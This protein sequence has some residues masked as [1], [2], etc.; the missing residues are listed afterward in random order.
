MEKS[1][2]EMSLEELWQLFPVILKAHNPCYKAWY[3]SEKQNIMQCINVEHIIRF[4]HIGSS[5]VENLISKPIIDILL[6]IDGCCD[7]VQ[8]V[9]DLATDGWTL[10]MQ[11]K[12]PTI[13]FAFNKGYMPNGF[14]QKVFHL[15]VRYFGDWSELYFRDYLFSHP[16]IAAEYGKLKLRILRKYKYDRDRYTEAKSD[17]ILRCSSIAK[18]ELKQKYKPRYTE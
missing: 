12:E 18:E 4:N 9:H 1:L 2:S 5:A 17:F 7:V 13:K 8:L 11:E 14:A 6:E 16:E 15:H 10:M 3:E